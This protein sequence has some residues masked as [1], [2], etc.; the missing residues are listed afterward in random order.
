MLGEGLLPQRKRG[1][2]KGLV[3]LFESECLLSVKLFSFSDVRD[4][5]KR[6]NER[7]AKSKER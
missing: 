6:M 5:R 4:P 2:G 1:W 3:E 7:A